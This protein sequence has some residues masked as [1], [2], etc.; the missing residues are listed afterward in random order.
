MCVA[1]V[2]PE[3]PVTQPVAT[4][5]PGLSWVLAMKSDP[6]FYVYVLFRPWN[7]QPC[8][9]GKGFG[10]RWRRHNAVA[11]RHSNKHLANIFRKAG[12]EIPSVIVRNQLTEKEAF[13]LERILIGII[14]RHNIG[15]GPLANLTDGGDGVSGLRHNDEFRAQA[16]IRAAKMGAAQRGKVHSTETRE[17]M[18]K[19]AYR[20]LQN[21]ALREKRRLA[22]I[23]L[24]LSPEVKAK[25]S[26]A[27]KG[28]KH[29]EETRAKMSAA[30][31]PEMCAKLG[32]SNKTRDYTPEIRAKMRANRLGKKHTEETRAKIKAAAGNLSQEARAK[33]SATHLGK[34]K[35]PESIAKRL[36]TIRRNRLALMQ[37]RNE[38]L[39]YTDAPPP[40][41]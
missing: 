24:H 29:T 39:D 9:V 25:I 36:A 30:K 23:G 11:E 20:A 15:K 40:P 27:N 38:D 14:G 2:A 22:H 10:R 41:I 8:Y 16:A 28:R 4:H 17:R 3:P 1:R 5:T 37:Q 13:D 32:E 18:S 21:P 33:I 26:A 34:K 6:I 12:G 31:T 35:S 7:G 19:S